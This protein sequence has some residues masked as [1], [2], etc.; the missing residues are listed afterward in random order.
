MLLV[1][2]FSAA[3]VTPHIRACVTQVFHRPYLVI[4]TVAC[5]ERIRAHAWSTAMVSPSSFISSHRA[6]ASRPSSGPGE[7]GQLQGNRESQEGCGQSGYRS[8]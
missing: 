7:N 4:Q 8:Q 2:L 3:K 6:S 5:P 1:V